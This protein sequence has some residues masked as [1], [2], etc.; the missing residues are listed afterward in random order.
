APQ[1]VHR[2]WGWYEVLLEDQF[3]KIKRIE[4][5]P[6][7]SL[8]LQRHR[9]RSEHWV[10]VSGAAEVVRGEEKLFV[11]QSESTFIPPGVVHRLANAG[12]IPLRIIEVQLGEYLGEDDIERLED[13]YGRN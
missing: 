7:A 8:S 4:V 11:A 3:Y 2:P 6:G 9:H 1:R 13:A 5:K 12:K 10:V